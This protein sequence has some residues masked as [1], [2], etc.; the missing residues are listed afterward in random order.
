MMPTIDA[1]RT[2]RRA[3]PALAATAFLWTAACSSP[4][5][6]GGPDGGGGSGGAAGGGSGRH[7]GAGA[8]GAG[9]SA[10]GGDGGGSVDAG[11]IVAPQPLSPNIVVDQFG[12]RTAA[13][14]IAV[15]RSPQTGF[16]ATATFTPGAKYALVDAHSGAMLLEAAPAA[17]NTGK[18]DTSSGDKAWWFDFSTVTTAGDYFV[19]DEGQD[20]RSDVFAISDG[21]YRDVLAQATRMLFYQRDGFAKTA[22]FA[23]TAWADT[24][25]HTGKC[26]LYSDTGKTLNQDLHGGWWDAG[27]FNKYSN[28]GASDVIE[29]LRAYSESPAAFT[30]A[31]NIPESGNGVSDILDETKW[32]LDWLTRMQ[33][34]DGSVLSIVDEPSAEAPAFGGSPNTAPSTV[35]DACFYGPANTSAALT[36]A[37]AFAYASVVMGAAPGFA[38]AYP[39]YTADLAQRA[40]R[41]WTWAQAN[42]AVF[43]YNSTASPQVGAGEQEVPNTEPDRTY[44]LT[45]KKLQASLYLYE[46]TGTTSYR[47]TFDANYATMNL[48]RSGYADSS[49]GEEQE[50]L[51]AYTQAAS[52]TATVVQKIKSSYLGAVK[53]STNLGSVTGNADPYLAYL[54]DYFWGSNQI[55][56]D[57]GNLLLDV[58]TFAVDDATAADAARGAERYIHYVHGVNPLQVVYLSNMGAFGAQ[59]SVTRF[60]HSWY[61]KGS[62]W[63][64][65]GVS[66]Y[67]P[68]P[69]YLTGGPNP[70]YAWDGCCPSGC[71]GYSCGAAQLSPPI[72]QP[73]QKSYLDFNDGWPLDSWSVTEPDDGYQAKYIRLL[74]KFVQ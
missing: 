31:T 59:K 29:L 69:G 52:P 65:A 24:A 26:Y 2:R 12:Y 67:G 34:T 1:P 53:T 15:I 8:T 30:D 73:D 63:D 58:V 44:S 37:A 57:Q 36:T 16:D 7:G 40:A 20:V 45:V 60:F 27:D 32:E 61:A 43:F 35:T 64:A 41:A 9:G 55:K 70:S 11:P 14:K 47:D 39:G 3:W 13:E 22:A 46:A 19:L 66:M 54:Q 21:V 72:G 49:H 33:Q 56:A 51:L 4:S 28:W 5:A 74:S 25:A 50:T 38:A 62:N 10:A 42:P 48:I 6:G 23:G 17:W 18:T 71:S 68:P